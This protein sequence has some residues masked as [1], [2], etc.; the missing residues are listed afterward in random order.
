M[1]GRGSGPTHWHS[2]IILLFMVQEPPLL[3][4]PMQVRQLG[5]T[6]PS[7]QLREGVRGWAGLL[8]GV[9]DAKEGA[10]QG[11]QGAG[12]GTGLGAHSQDGA[13]L[14]GRALLTCR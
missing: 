5:A 2:G 8:R 10:V 11:W 4:W 12:L 7:V 1:P 13:A 6:R 3:Q 9:C 14:A